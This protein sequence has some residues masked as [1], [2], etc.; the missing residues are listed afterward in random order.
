[1]T[2]ATTGR[3]ATPARHNNRLLPSLGI[4]LVTGGILLLAWFAW[5]WFNPGPSPYRYQLVEEGG[6]DKFSQLGLDAW[7]DLT[8][9]KY[10]VFAEEI[11]KP[12]ASGHT[13]RRGQTPPVLI[14]WENHTSE[15][16]ASVDSKLNELTALASAIN[17]YAGKDALILGWWDTSRQIKLLA[18]RDTLFNSHVGQPL[19]I[20]TPW[21]N[22]EEA[23]RKYED[24]FWG[25]RA[26]DEE[27]RKFERF[28]DALLAE[29][30]QGAAILRELA[31]GREAYIALHVTDLYK[32]GL[33]R[34]DQFDITYKNFPMEGNMHGLIG[35]LKNWMQEN[36]FTT[37]TLQSISDKMVRGYFLRT[38][39]NS[40]SLIA[41]MMPFTNSTPLDLQPVQLIYQQGGYWVY[42][43]PSADPAPVSANPAATPSAPDPAP[44]QGS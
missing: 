33:M 25:A 34:P 1:L 41:K 3:A 14:S 28:T 20:P 12:L 18:S 21:R 29:P 17:K 2:S 42:Q 40:N 13:A 7:P 8:I 36:N 27:R 43:I 32:L 16:I 9:A 4:L 19:I 30:E 10:D 31:G 39:K 6:V 37:Y 44:A 11:E 22:R 24:Q 26:S 5:L 23:I 15:L 35:Y 38:D